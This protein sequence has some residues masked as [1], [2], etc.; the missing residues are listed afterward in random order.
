MYMTKNLAL[1]CFPVDKFYYF[2]GLNAHTIYIVID[3]L[4]QYVGTSTYR[5]EAFQDAQDLL[6]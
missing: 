2:A 3:E 6:H 4:K 5:L 1:E